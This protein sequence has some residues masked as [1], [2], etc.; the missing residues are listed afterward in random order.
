MRQ[1]SLWAASKF[2]GERDPTFGLRLIRSREMDLEP[3]RDLC[4]RQIGTGLSPLKKMIRWHQH[5]NE[6]FHILVQLKLPGDDLVAFETVRVDGYFGVFP[7]RKAAC[8]ALDEDQL[9]G[10]SF[11]TEHICKP[12]HGAAGYYIAGIAGR[13][14]AANFRIVKELRKHI[15]TLVATGP[16]VFYTR[17]VTKIGLYLVKEFAFE[18]LDKSKLLVLNELCKKQLSKDELA[19]RKGGLGRD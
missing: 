18:R 17:P 3:A 6:I 10:L 4:L 9:D 8:Q 2:M 13:Y 15:A 1:I 5:N 7:L 16:K 11:T 12:G 14:P 19:A